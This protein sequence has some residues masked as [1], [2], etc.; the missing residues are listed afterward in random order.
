MIKV[1]VHVEEIQRRLDTFRQRLKNTRPL[2][3][4]IADIMYDSTIQNFRAGGR[5]KWVESKAAI[6]RGG[7]TLIDKGN[8][9]GLL[10][11]IHE[12]YGADYAMVG[13]NKA[14]AA[15]HQF[16][17]TIKHKARRGV[18]VH[19]KKNGKGHLFAKSDEAD[20]GMKLNYKGYK[21]SM[22]ARPYFKLQPD[23]LANIEA[24]S[25]SYLEDK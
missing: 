14:Y 25:M 2:M 11:S 22:P 17:G 15:I 19:F 21:T 16:G 23:E 6:K 18:P 3:H 4:E 24:T 10:G 8:N 5:P 20:Y 9:G 13:T 7:Q 1:Q 12:A